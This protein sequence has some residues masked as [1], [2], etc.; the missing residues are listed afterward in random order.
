MLRAAGTLV[1]GKHT[2]QL[3]IIPPCPFIIRLPFAAGCDGAAWVIYSERPALGSYAADVPFVH[4]RHD[5]MEK[6][7]KKHLF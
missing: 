7:R 3:L 5:R 4:D 1:D 2:H 6:E